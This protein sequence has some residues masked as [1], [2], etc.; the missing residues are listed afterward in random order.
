MIDLLLAVVKDCKGFGETSVFLVGCPQIWL[1]YFLEEDLIV[2]DGEPLVPDD[3]MLYLILLVKLFV[4]A[5][6]GLGELGYGDNILLN[7]AVQLLL[8]YRK[9]I[10]RTDMSVSVIIIHLE[11]N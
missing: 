8:E 4:A 7:R 11:R 2:F 9:H 3:D 1:I 5:G 10:L 6:A